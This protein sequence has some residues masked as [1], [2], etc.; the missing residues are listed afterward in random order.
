MLRWEDSSWAAQDPEA[1]MSREELST[2]VYAFVVV[3]CHR[4]TMEAAVINTPT[5]ALTPSTVDWRPEL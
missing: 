5:N 2:S 4:L 1:S 3:C